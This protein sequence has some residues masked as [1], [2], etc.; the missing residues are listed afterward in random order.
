MGRFQTMN[1]FSFSVGPEKLQI[2][3]YN[4]IIWSLNRQALARWI[5]R[6]NDQV[7]STAPHP[8]SNTFPCLQYLI[9]AGK[10]VVTGVTGPASHILAEGWSGAHAVV[11]I[12]NSTPRICL[13]FSWAPQS[14]PALVAGSPVINCDGHRIRPANAEN[15][16]W[17]ISLLCSQSFKFS[18]FSFLN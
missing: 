8:I 17:S 4:V 10:I 13:T 15:P 18:Y 5:W 1:Q 3:S 14:V 16:L 12:S 11:P 7:Q 9:W 6:T 2:Y